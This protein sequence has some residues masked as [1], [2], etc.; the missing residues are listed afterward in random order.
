MPYWKKTILPEIQHGKRLLIVSHQHVL[1][2]LMMELDGFSAIHLMT[3][4]IATGRPLV[5]QLDSELKPVGH[6][7]VDHRRE[8]HAY[9]S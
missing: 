5:Y 9:S 7:Y 2:T 4:S 6:Y 8:N 3:L 1:R